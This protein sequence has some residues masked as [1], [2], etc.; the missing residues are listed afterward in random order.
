MEE[1]RTDVDIA[2]HLLVDCFL[3][4]FDEAVVISNDSDLVSPIE[5]VKSTFGKTIGVI[6]P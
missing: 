2:T 5:M 4:D 3:D 6:N 1:K